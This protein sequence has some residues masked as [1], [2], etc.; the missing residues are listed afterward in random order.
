MDKSKASQ[1]AIG[2]EK[3]MLFT[4]F[5]G[6][7]M[8]FMGGGGGLGTGFGNDKSENMLGKCE[9]ISKDISF[10]KLLPPLQRNF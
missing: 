10:C 5:I 8:N 6:T 9:K 2:K 4:P 1:N 3:Q 7:G